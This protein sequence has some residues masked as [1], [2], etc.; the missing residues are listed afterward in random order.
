[1]SSHPSRNHWCKESLCIGRL[2][3]SKREEGDG[4]FKSRVA[5][6]E[7]G[8]QGSCCKYCFATE[9]VVGARVGSSARVCRVVV[10]RGQP[11]A[12]C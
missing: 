8:A 10:C 9:G 6:L 5:V 2:G 1:M 12:F 7:V 4:R 11:G 3:S